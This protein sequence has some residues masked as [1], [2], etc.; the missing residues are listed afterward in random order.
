MPRKVLRRVQGGLS[1]P[2]SRTA[3]GNT[4]LG[5]CRRTAPTPPHRPRRSPADPNTRPHA[6]P[7][8]GGRRSE[9]TTRLRRTQQERTAIVRGVARGCGLPPYESP[10]NWQ[11]RFGSAC[12]LLGAIEPIG[13]TFRLL[14]ERASAFGGMPSAALVGTLAGMPESSL[15]VCR[16][17]PT[18]SLSLCV[19]AI[20]TWA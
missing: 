8:V 5:R 20:N 4:E 18:M 1:S 6:V 15:C 2:C 16:C 13:K 7:V 10:A 17:P 11:V 12:C 3:I 14:I 9:R 19:G